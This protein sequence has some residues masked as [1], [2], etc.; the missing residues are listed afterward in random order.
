ML[1]SEEWTNW[2]TATHRCLWIHGIPGA[3]KTIL[4]S[5]LIE[6]VKEHC[7]Q[8]P[9]GKIAHIYYY[10]Y[11]GRNQDEAMPFLRWIISK[12]SRQAEVVSHQAYELYKRGGEPSLVE[13]LESLETAL[14]NFDNAYVV[15]DA[16]DE[17]SPRSDILKIIRDLATDSRFSKVQVLVTSR[18]YVDIERAMESIS[19][20][21]SMSNPLVK[22]DIRSHVRSALRS[23]LKFRRWPS[24][25]LTEVEDAVST[26]AK[27]MYETCTMLYSR[28]SY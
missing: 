22:E 28:V 23:N 15:I 13:L 25:L 1:R 21:V 9:K 4:A 11:F 7:H 14:Q 20:F 6:K 8:Q 2:L 18:E 16:V 24:D 17:S 26:E 12:L 27:G 3:G 10:C 5:W 19:V